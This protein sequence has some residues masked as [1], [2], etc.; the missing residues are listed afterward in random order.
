[1]GDRARRIGAFFDVDKTILSENSGAL[2]FKLLYERGEM[3]TPTALRHMGA[4]LRYKFNLLDIENWT[5]STMATF[6]GRNKED[7]DREAEDWFRES[8]LPTVYPEA[9][10][11]VRDHMQRG[12]VVALVTGSTKFVVRPLARFLGVEHLLYTHLEVADGLFTGRVI[13]PICF[14]EGKIYWLQ[15]LIERESIDLAKSY[16]YTDSITDLPVLDLVGHPQ[17]VNPDP[18]LYREAVRRRWPVRLFEEPGSA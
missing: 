8:V 5:K 18:L 17:V 12:H 11:A 4:Y 1:M 9:I 3:D 6:A 13:E 7:L 14:G 2:Y 10:E 15:Q 16:F